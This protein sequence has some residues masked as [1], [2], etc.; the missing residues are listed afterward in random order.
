[1]AAPLHEWSSTEKS[2]NQSER[3]SCKS[4]GFFVVL[5]LAL[6]ESAVPAGDDPGELE[7][8]ILLKY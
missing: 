4:V 1:M 2:Y 7:T 5:N 6:S 3:T 8:G